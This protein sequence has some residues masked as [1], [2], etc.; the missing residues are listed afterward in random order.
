M[1]SLNLLLPHEDD[2]V[3][4]RGPII[5][6]AVKQFWTDV[7]WGEIDYLV[8]DL[9]PGTGD[10]P[11]TVMQSLPL[12]GLLIVTSPQELAIMV[13]KKAIKMARMLEV[14]ILGLVE[15]MSG[16]LCPHCGKPVEDVYKRQT[17]CR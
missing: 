14:P 2:P 4:W 9:P 1:I 16:L 8:V 11:L 17:H 10:A 15:N 5:G 13:V 3:I 7:L 6:G 12:D